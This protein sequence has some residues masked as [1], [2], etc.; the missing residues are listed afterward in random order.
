MKLFFRIFFLGFLLI[1]S[2]S[3]IAEENKPL[4]DENGYCGLC[5]QD[6]VV[7]SMCE[8]SIEGWKEIGYPQG[9]CVRNIYDSTLPWLCQVELP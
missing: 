3:A 4:P 6:A 1:S 9:R 8:C 5:T 2:L 7:G